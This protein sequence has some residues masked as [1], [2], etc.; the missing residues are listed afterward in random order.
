MCQFTIPFSGAP[1]LLI[2]RAQ[3]EIG[4]AGGS[5]AGDNLQGNFEVK[6]PLGTVRGKYLMVTNG[7]AVTILKKPLLVSCT[8]IEK[9][10]K[11]VM[12]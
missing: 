5:F 12:V 9:E 11:E 10:L 8:R 6:T 2:G 7:I 4:A 3:R 1:D